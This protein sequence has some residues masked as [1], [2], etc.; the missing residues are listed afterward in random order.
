MEIFYRKI[1]FCL[2]C[3][4]KLAF[5]AHAHGWTKKKAYVTV[6]ITGGTSVR[7]NHVVRLRS[8]QQNGLTGK[9]DASVI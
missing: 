6:W 2:F 7:W 1:Q 4:T 5:L 9:A 3:H 8:N